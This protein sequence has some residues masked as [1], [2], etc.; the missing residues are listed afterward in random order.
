MSYRCR[1]VTHARALLAA[2]FQTACKFNDEVQR[3]KA[4]ITDLEDANEI[5]K[6]RTTAAQEE[7]EERR[8]ELEDARN[9]QAA[10]EA[11]FDEVMLLVQQ[12]EAEKREV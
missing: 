9:N 6:G 11:K 10:A 1:D 5:L 7:F 8:A 12:S 4:E 2:L 3:T